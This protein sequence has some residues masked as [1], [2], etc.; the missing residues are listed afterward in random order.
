MQ[1]CLGADLRAQA[2]ALSVVHEPLLVRRGEVMSMEVKCRR[3]DLLIADGMPI[4]AVLEN[5]GNW[6]RGGFHFLCALQVEIE[7]MQK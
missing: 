4:I 1:A 7:R 2:E 5:N 3:C 6:I